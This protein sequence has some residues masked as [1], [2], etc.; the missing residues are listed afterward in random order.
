MSNGTFC[1]LPSHTA[2]DV[3]AVMEI[4][5]VLFSATAL[6]LTH[7]VYFSCVFFKCRN[8]YLP[9]PHSF[10]FSFVFSQEVGA[11][12]RGVNCT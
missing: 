6:P 1:A 9:W 2:F 4:I 12:K 10:L 8:I 3:G 7:V 11:S 5:F